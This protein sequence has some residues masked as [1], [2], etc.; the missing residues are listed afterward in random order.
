[1]RLLRR[2]WDHVTSE[3]FSFKTGYSLALYMP[4]QSPSRRVGAW[5]C[6]WRSAS[7]PGTSQYR[8]SAP[9]IHNA[10]YW[11]GLGRQGHRGQS[12]L[13]PRNTDQMLLFLLPPHKLRFLYIISTSFYVEYLLERVLRGRPMRIRY[14]ANNDTS[15]FLDGFE[16]RLKASNQTERFEPLDLVTTDMLSKGSSPRWCSWK[17]HSR[18]RGSARLQS[19]ARRHYASRHKAQTI[20]GLNLCSSC[21]PP[22]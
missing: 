22:R 18:A 5:S 4:S 2:A 3:I 12:R 7:L 9:S 14:G 21:H 20:A 13:F 11:D 19:H 1:M 8:S 6:L 10:P 16:F 17:S 15:K